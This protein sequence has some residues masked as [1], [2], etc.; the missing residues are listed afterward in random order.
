MKKVLPAVLLALLAGCTAP[1]HPWAPQHQS[2]R[3]QAGSLPQLTQASAAGAFGAQATSQRRLLVMPEAGV[4]PVLQA[5]RGAKTSIRMHMYLFMTSSLGAQVLEALAERSKAGVDVRIILDGAPFT[6]PKPPECQPP[7]NPVSN[8]QPAFD[9]LRAAGVKVKWS[10]PKFR[11]THQKS[12]VIDGQAA[13][14]MTSNMTSSAFKSNREYIVVDRERSDV[15]DI[16]R[17]FEADWAGTSYVP[18]DPDLVVS[19]NNSRQRILALIDS[20]REELL[21]QVEYMGDKEVYAHLGA[22]VRAGVD[23]TV[24]VAHTEKGP[25]STWDTGAEEAKALAAAGVTKVAFIKKVK[26]HAKAVV[27]DGARAYV[28]SVNFTSNSLNNNRE[29]GLLLADRPVVNELRAVMARDWAEREA[30]GPGTATDGADGGRI[31]AFGL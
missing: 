10:D 3:G 25:C 16:T 8:N 27:A 2:F 28:G 6:A 1:A 14:V 21:M 13:W 11:F 29:L 23:V 20:A 22:R 7:A 5:I 26:L 19:P 17:L 4:E 12:M 24:M 18:R 30:S 31:A 9:A 15:A